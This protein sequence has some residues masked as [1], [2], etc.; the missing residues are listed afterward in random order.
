MLPAAAQASMAGEFDPIEFMHCHGQGCLM[1]SSR[2]R[3]GVLRSVFNFKLLVHLF[4]S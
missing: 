2:S 1:E 4:V 3:A